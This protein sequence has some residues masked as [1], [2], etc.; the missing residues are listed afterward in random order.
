M[1]TEP[2]EE[3]EDEG[4]KVRLDEREGMETVGLE[5]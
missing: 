4:V 1:V 3:W 5:K 2:R